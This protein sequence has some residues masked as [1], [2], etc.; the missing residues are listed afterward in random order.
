MTLP[1]NGMPGLP[2]IFE[3]YSNWGRWGP[4]DERGTLNLIDARAV[5]RA[6]ACV[7]AGEVVPLGQIPPPGEFGNEAAAVRLRVYSTTGERRDALDV[8]TV[9]SHGYDI[10]H[11]DAVCHSFFGGLAYNARRAEEVV[12]DSGLSFGGIDAMRGGIVT[13]GVLLDVAEYRNTV[14]LPAADAITGD[15]LSEAERL[16]GAEV[17]PG[18]AVFVRANLASGA[19][20][21][22][23][24]PGLVASAVVWL[25]ERDVGVYSGDCIEKVPG[26]DPDIAMVLHQVGHVA[27]GLA[28]LDNPVV[29][30]LKYACHRHGRTTFMLAVAPLPI[31]GATG[32]PVNPLAI[33]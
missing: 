12:A 28:I 14:G 16:G 20:T 24:R 2:A 21:K 32:C 7:I 33:F 18:D 15:D 3:R 25:R 6:L 13:R 31:V 30:V 27:M 9:A 29:E 5:Q 22:E 19:P 10:T 26:D 8:L 4:E 17:L 23:T 11:M 1:L